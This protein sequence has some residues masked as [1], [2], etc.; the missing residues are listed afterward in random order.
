MKNLA[1]S[2]HPRRAKVAAA[3][4]TRQQSLGLSLARQKIAVS[5]LASELQGSSRSLQCRRS[6]CPSF[7]VPSQ[8]PRGHSNGVRPESASPPRAVLTRNL[9]T[10]TRA[11]QVVSLSPPHPLLLQMP[12]YSV[13]N[14][15]DQLSLIKKLGI[16]CD[17]DKHV[18]PLGLMMLFLQPAR[19]SISSSLRP[20]REL[21]GSICVISQSVKVE[22]PS[23]GQNFFLFFSS[24]C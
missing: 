17:P 4:E 15:D 19:M 3:L 2:L 20:G 8:T 10:A 12:G 1:A 22:Q 14:T 18:S 16:Y 7:T 21:R 6:S 5:G 24:S 11:Q 9:F 23:H 13:R